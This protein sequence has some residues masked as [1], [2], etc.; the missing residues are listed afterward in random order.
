M[1]TTPIPTSLQQLKVEFDA[2]RQSKPTPQSRIPLA[3]RQRAAALR[4]QYSD[5]DITR[6]LSITEARLLKWAGEAPSSQ[7]AAAAPASPEGF[8]AV[9]LPSA[10]DAEVSPGAALGQDN[11][12]IELQGGLGQAVQWRLQG[13][14]SPPQLQ[15]LVASLLQGSGGV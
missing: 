15:A 2:W 10:P 8:I 11:P 6:L 14:F 1:S 7:P 12:I 9:T 3:L 4:G 5:R 13:P